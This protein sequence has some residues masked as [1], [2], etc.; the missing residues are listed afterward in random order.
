MKTLA[1]WL[2]AAA[3]AAAIPAVSAQ[4]AAPPALTARTF[5]GKP[6]DLASLKGKVV[7]LMFWSTDCAVCR[8]KMPEL[9]ANHEGW[10]GR[11]FELVLVSTDKR[12][13]DVVAYEQVIARTVPKSQRFVQLWTGDAAYRDSIGKPAALPYTL[14]LDKAGRIVERYTGRVPAEAWDRIADLL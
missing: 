1:R 5:D 6:F 7:L 12:M 13:E 10:K 4:P 11:P 2:L 3:L 14:L 8:D 9:R